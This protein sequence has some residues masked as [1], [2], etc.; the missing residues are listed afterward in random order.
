GETRWSARTQVGRASRPTP[1]L[2]SEV[3]HF[4]IN[5]TWTVP[6]TILRNDK[7][8][9]I[10]RDIGYLERNNMRVLDHRGN[11]LN[12]YEVDWNNPSGIMLRQDAGPQN[13]LGQVAIRFPNPFSVYLH[14][15]PSQSIF[16]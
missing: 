6:P 10:R 2:K 1:T 3:T 12:P 8:P 5:P 4:T 7:L 11:R 16:G 9:E 15:T 14:D 13:A